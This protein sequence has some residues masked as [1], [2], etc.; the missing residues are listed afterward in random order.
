MNKGRAREEQGMSKH[1]LSQLC[2]INMNCIVCTMRQLSFV[3]EIMQLAAFPLRNLRDLREKR[4]FTCKERARKE[5]GY[6][7]TAL[8]HKHELHD[9]T[10]RQL[11]FICEIMQ[12][13]AFL[14]VI[15]VICGRHRPLTSKGRVRNEQACSLTALLYKHEL[16]CL[17]YVATV[18]S[19]RNNAACCIPSA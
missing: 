7:L 4:P 18:F 3:C 11:S 10:M 1:V 14:C 6:P 12:L 16:H 17:H 19:L 15:S 8:L 2:C 5:R 9:S 13:A